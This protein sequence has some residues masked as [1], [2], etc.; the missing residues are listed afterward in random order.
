M[1]NNLI[2]LSDN[3]MSLNLEGLTIGYNPYL[4]ITKEFADKYHRQITINY[5]AVMQRFKSIM[6]AKKRLFRLKYCFQ[7]EIQIDKYRYRFG[8]PGYLE[9]RDKNKGLFADT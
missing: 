3:I 5:S 7:L 6:S 4:H 2:A 1:N 8:G 9:L